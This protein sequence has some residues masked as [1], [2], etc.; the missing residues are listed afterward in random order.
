[1]AAR[2]AVY[3]QA[4]LSPTRAWAELAGETQLG[5]HALEIAQNVRDLLERGGR[6]A[7]AVAQA[8]GAG[9]EAARVLS[10]V[11]AVADESGTPLAQAMWTLSQSLRERI[12][13]E[14]DID[15]ISRAP[16]QTAVLLM[17]LP[18]LGLTMAWLLGVNAVSFLL[19]SALGLFSLLL[20][21]L[22]YALAWWWMR[23]LVSQLLPEQGYLSP[24]RDL[25]AVATAGGALPEVAGD[26][27]SRVLADNHLEPADE[28]LSQ[29]TGLS[30]RVGI[31]IQALATAEA[32][33][34]REHARA[35]A[36]RAAASLSVKILIPLGLLVLP[37]FVLVAVIPVLFTLLTSALGPT[38]Q[39]W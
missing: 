18:P 7:E 17:G 30:R 8:T 25:L 28:A 37:A 32:T 13:V 27:V 29:L 14:A 3:L 39:A 22:L 19:G 11:I 26:R 33:W 2:L 16:K 1:M 9:G 20:A 31:P 10:A 4:G 15:A 34:V 12:V 38:L 5:S 24:A 21:L 6:H 23:R 35:A 36:A